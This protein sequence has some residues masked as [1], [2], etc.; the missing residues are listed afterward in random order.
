MIYVKQWKM[1]VVDVVCTEV[2]YN[3]SFKV[4]LSDALT[5][6]FPICLLLSFLIVPSKLCYSE[7]FGSEIGAIYKLLIALK[8]R[9]PFSLPFSLSKYP[10]AP[11]SSHGSSTPI[12]ATL[13]PSGTF[14]D[15]GQSTRWRCNITS[16]SSIFNGM[17]TK[18]Y[19][20]QVHM[21]WHPWHR[22]NIST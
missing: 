8:K 17:E 5:Y 10:P 22:N 11:F 3:S 1:R 6:S 2:L 14:I 16:I 13:R 7:L 12:T 9:S 21:C 4:I 18:I 15:Q 20:E 19:N